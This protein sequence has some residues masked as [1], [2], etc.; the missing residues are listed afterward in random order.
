VREHN[1]SKN[2]VALLAYDPRIHRKKIFVRLM[3]C[4]VKPG[5]DRIA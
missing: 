1:R 4:R 3:D 2:G 5:N